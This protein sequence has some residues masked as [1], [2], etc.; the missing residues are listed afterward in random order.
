M[1]LRRF[2]WYLL[3]EYYCILAMYFGNDNATC[4][5]FQ[6][7]NQTSLSTPR[8]LLCLLPHAISPHRAVAPAVTAP[9][10]HLSRYFLRTFLF[11]HAAQFRRRRDSARPLLIGPRCQP[12]TQ[13]RCI[14]QGSSPPSLGVPIKTCYPAPTTCKP[15]QGFGA[16][17]HGRARRT[18]GRGGQQQR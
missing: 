12:T 16:G 11:P 10:N 18:G 17:V 6:R 8:P 2:F 9:N 15:K 4:I 5:G 1:S 7:I 14:R 3:F 13:P